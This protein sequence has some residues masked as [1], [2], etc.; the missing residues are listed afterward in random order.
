MHCGVGAPPQCI[1]LG[2][3]LVVAAAVWLFFAVETVNL[4]DRVEG[5]TAYIVTPAGLGGKT[6][7]LGRDLFVQLVSTR[8]DATAH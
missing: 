6:G 3:V 2:E 1:V 8:L 7:R 4:V 5:V